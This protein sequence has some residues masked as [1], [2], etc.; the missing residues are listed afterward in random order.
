MYSP[1]KLLQACL[2]ND[3]LELSW[4]VVTKENKLL[5]RKILFEKNVNDRI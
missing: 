5:R 4:F 1:S 2:M 3:D